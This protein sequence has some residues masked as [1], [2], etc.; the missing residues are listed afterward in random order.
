MKNFLS[1]IGNKKA[2]I[3]FHS[4]GDLDAIGAAIAVKRGLENADIVA[5]DRPNSAARRLA[6]KLGEKIF[7]FD[8]VELE[9][10]RKFIVLDTNSRALLPQMD[11]FMPDCIIDH[12][13]VHDDMP[14]AE[15][16]FIDKKAS[17]TSE[18]VADGLGEFDK[19]SATALAVGIVSDSANFRS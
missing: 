4:L 16:V 1:G 8:D 19:A 18:I 14:K 2:L 11:K 15:K 6:E 5:P 13:N 3:T 7:L 9:D 17:S 10:Y 12:H